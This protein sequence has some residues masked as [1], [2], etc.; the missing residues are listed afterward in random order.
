MSFK[1]VPSKGNSQ[2]APRKAGSTFHIGICHPLTEQ[3]VAILTAV[4]QGL[5][6]DVAGAMKQVQEMI[7]SPAVWLGAATET[8][9]RDGQSHPFMKDGKPSLNNGSVWV[10]TEDPTRSRG[11]EEKAGLLLK[12]QS[13]FAS[14]VTESHPL[15]EAAQAAYQ[16]ECG[17]GAPAQPATLARAVGAARAAQPGSEEV[18]P[19]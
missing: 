17:I 12:A 18:Q 9:T 8:R 13:N 3:I 4:A 6:E 16:A 2:A 11:R 10:Y 1:Y 15:W 14:V 5:V 7:E 19:G